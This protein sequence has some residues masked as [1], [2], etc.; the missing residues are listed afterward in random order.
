MLQL[1]KKNYIVKRCK[2]SKSIQQLDTLEE[3]LDE[4]NRKLS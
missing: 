2:K 4:K 3:D 1:R